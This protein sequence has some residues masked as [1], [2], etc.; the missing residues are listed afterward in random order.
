[1]MH[2]DVIVIGL[3]VVGA[4]AAYHLANDGQRVLALEQFE[5]NHRNGS[6]YGESRI[7]RYAYDHPL[8]TE[9][10]K[11]AFPM[12]RA[13]EAASN[14]RLMF[15]TGG[16][17]FGPADAPTLVGT[18][19]NLEAAGVPFE[20][21]EPAEAMARFPQ[22]RLREG[23]AAL[24]QPDAAY[25][26]ASSCVLGLVDLARWKGASLQVGTPVTAIEPLVG[27]V[28]VRTTEQVYEAGRV[29]IAAGA[30]AGP[31]LAGL[32][33]RL[34][35]Q[36]T[37]EQLVYFESPEPALF[38]PQR[39][40]VFIFHDHPWFYGLPNVDGFGV[41]VAVHC[42]GETTDP[43]QTRRTVDPDYIERVRAWASEYLPRAVGPVCETRVCLY[44]MTP[45]EHFV[46][47]RH[48]QY[49]HVVYASAC[50]GHGFKF[51]ILTGRILADLVTHGTT[52]YEIGLFS[53]S[54]FGE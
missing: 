37:R 9:M 22:F 47:D 13:L 53:A 38:T 16:F 10:A 11:D 19:R 26:A 54:R 44:T 25:L 39:C 17:D 45:D 28:R 52:D 8:Y 5:L 27:A 20:W 36:P 49:P 35:L 50:S 43:N 48:P 3:G 7:I 51:G 40:P 32:G 29:V 34:P 12:W 6:S 33:I 30:W 2:Y 4:A 18:R 42:N 21:L 46:I 1:M 24:Y 31:M 15:R 14:K 23:M 41:K